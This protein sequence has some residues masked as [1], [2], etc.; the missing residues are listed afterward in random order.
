MARYIEYYPDGG[1]DCYVD[2]GGIKPTA[3]NKSGVLFEVLNGIAKHVEDFK[4]PMYIVWEKGITDNT[5]HI[6][7]EKPEPP[8]LFVEFIN[9]VP[10]LPPPNSMKENTGP[11][12][13]IS[14]ATISGS[15]TS[16]LPMGS[17]SMPF[18][19]VS[20][21]PLKSL[22]DSSERLPTIEQVEDAFKNIKI[23]NTKITTE[24]KKAYKSSNFNEYMENNVLI[25]DPFNKL[26][27]NTIK[28]IILKGVKTFTND[29]AS[30]DVEEA[31]E[32]LQS[33]IFNAINSYALKL[34][35]I[36]T[37]QIAEYTKATLKMLQYALT[38]KI[39]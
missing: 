27:G 1:D 37:Q 35:G 6:V 14:A 12:P 4:N 10:T 15:P 20:S 29:A 3:I 32:S 38:N 7:F 13:V 11:Q 25:R 34:P 8:T 36:T 9:G 2:H 18:P 17:F 21:A 23:D 16:T 33:N 28:Q 30:K 31:A 22:P 26:F 5:Y 39:L 19:P 24:F